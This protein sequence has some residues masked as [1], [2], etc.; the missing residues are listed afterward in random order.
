MVTE[1][2]V[3]GHENLKQFLE[4]FKNTKTDLYILFSGKKDETGVSWCSDCK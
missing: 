2:Y 1:K 3:E 4:T